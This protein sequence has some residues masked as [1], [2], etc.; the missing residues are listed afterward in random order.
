LE[1]YVGSEPDAKRL[2]LAYTGLVIIR[3]TIESDLKIRL[4]RVERWA[5]VGTG[6]IRLPGVRIRK[7]RIVGENSVATSDVSAS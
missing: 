3:P 1:E 4:V 7:G 6:A 2:C 5:S